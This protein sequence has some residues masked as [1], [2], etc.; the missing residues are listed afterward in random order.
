MKAAGLS[1]IFA[2][3]G[4]RPAAAAPDFDALAA[5]ARATLAAM[6]EADTTNPPGN[7]ARIVALAAA[8]LKAA[9]IPF[10]ITE[11]APG[12]RNIT[13]RLR[14]AGDGKPV[15]LLAHT[16][17]VGADGQAW[18]FPA[19]KLTEKDGFLYGRGTDDMLGMAAVNLEVF[20]EL[21]RSGAALRRDVILALTGDE[22]SGGA[23]IR[24]IL[25]RDPKSLDAG[26][27][28]N[29]CGKP[30]LDEEGR[31]RL[32]KIEVAQKIYA[33]F[34]LTAEGT[35]GHSSI[36]I[37]DNA[38]YRLSRALA[39]LGSHKFPV[40]L[41][42]VVRASF[43]ARAPLEKPEV[44]RAMKALAESDG[45]LPAGAVKVIESDPIL[46]PQ[47]RTTCVATLLSGGTRANALPA[48][49]KAIV[50]CRVL[51]GET[52]EGVRKE[53]AGA[54]ADP[55]VA[56]SALGEFRPAESSP[57]DSEDLR[58]VAGVI[59]RRWPGARVVPSLTLGAS[60]LLFLRQ[61]GIPAYGLSPLPISDAD[62][63][64]DHGVD[65]RIPAASL[66]VG[67]EFLHELILS[68]AGAK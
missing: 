43:A 50:N 31:V 34:E 5:S 10:E 61:L 6:V 2:L 39:R 16:D 56:L 45:E 23:G 26:F 47:L 21:K 4:A 28:F 15:L 37:E 46:A 48:Q 35:T 49:A 29:E 13:A 7:E 54:I 52:L 30:V 51:P 22:E 62:S 20:L 19:H 9:G 11:F 32:V 1:V 41:L 64:R 8:K 65:E 66:R 17:V 57:V 12:R 60:D 33:D 58:A 63:R 42:P 53:L 44:G 36:P 67:V 25:A 14:G 55:A 18:S 40:R 59:A 38:I 3:L 27:V 24:H 68:L